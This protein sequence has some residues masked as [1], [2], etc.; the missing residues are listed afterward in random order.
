MYACEA[1]PLLHKQINARVRLTKDASI[2]IS[3]TA[4]STIMTKSF[5]K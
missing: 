3:I 5:I 1:E 4:N 2:D